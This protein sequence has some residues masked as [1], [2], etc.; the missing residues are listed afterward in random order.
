MRSAIISQEVSSIDID[1]ATDKWNAAF[2][3]GSKL[4]DDH[5]AAA[6]DALMHAEADLEAHELLERVYANRRVSQMMKFAS[7]SKN[8]R[9]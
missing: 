6:R 1:R 8:M 5:T 7:S 3:R 2:D 9:L 4:A